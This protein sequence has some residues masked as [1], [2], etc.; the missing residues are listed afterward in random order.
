MKFAEKNQYEI[1]FEFKD[2]FYYNF[3]HVFKMKRP[4]IESCGLINKVSQLE[5]NSEFGRRNR[6]R[7]VKRVKN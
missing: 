2:F 4:D 3:I 1:P 5:N 6:K 7:I